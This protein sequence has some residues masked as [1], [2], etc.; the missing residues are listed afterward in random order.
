MGKPHKNNQLLRFF[1]G[2]KRETCKITD[3]LIMIGWAIL[4]AVTV[5]R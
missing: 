2:I 1:A 3:W 5:W 4:S